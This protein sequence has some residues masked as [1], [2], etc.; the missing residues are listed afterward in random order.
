MP[1]SKREQ[2]TLSRTAKKGRDR[3][4]AIMDEV[5]SAIDQYKNIFVFKADNMRNS[6]LKD[7]RARLKSSRIFFGRN[8]LIAAALGRTPEAEYRDALSQVAEHLLGGEAG[9]MFT[10]ESRDAVQQCFDDCQVSEFARAGAEATHEVALEAGPLVNF[11]HSMEPYLRK[12]GMPTKLSTGVVTLLGDYQVCREGEELSSDQAKVLQ[13]LG[14]KMAT[15]E[16]TL[17]CQ[18]CNGEFEA[19]E[20]VEEQ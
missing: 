14:I 12:L 9:L 15:F 8:K 2:V 5:R 16:L 20:E 17:C 4:G 11:P 1:K 19:F 7:V 18:W 6:G 13:L 10:D 3:K